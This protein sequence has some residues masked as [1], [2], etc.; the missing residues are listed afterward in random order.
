MIARSAQPD[1]PRRTPRRLLAIQRRPPHRNSPDRSPFHQSS[2]RRHSRSR[3]RHFHRVTFRR[4]PFPSLPHSASRRYG[5]EPTRTA[6]TAAAASSGSRTG[7]W[8]A[9]AS[10]S[11]R[12]TGGISAAARP[13]SR[14]GPACRRQGAHPSDGL[15]ARRQARWNRPRRHVSRYD[16]RHA[17]APVWKN[18]PVAAPEE[19]TRPFRHPSRQMFRSR[20]RRARQE[21]RRGSHRPCRATAESPFD[22]LNEKC[23]C[24]QREGTWA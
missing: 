16:S 3:C 2:T 19:E 23:P 11:P 8:S 6:G 15:L 12:G 17:T 22:P 1:C 14:T 10:P 9:P 4:Y 21:S 20:L 24:F 7:P 18:P 5:I 13:A